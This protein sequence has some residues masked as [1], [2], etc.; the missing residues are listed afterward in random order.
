MRKVVVTLWL[1]WWW[2]GQCF[3]Q[4]PVTTHTHP[5]FHPRTAVS[6]TV[7]NAYGQWRP[8]LNNSPTGKTEPSTNISQPAPGIHENTHHNKEN[9][10]PSVLPGTPS[11]KVHNGLN[12][13][14][15][16]HVIPSAKPPMNTSSDDHDHDASK[17]TSSG[18]DTT[19]GES[20]PRHLPD[21]L[22]SKNETH[23]HIHDHNP[24]HVSGELPVPE[25]STSEQPAPDMNKNTHHS[26]ENTPPTVLPVTQSEKVH[27][28]GLSWNS[29]KHVTPA[30]KPPVKT[31]RNDLANNA[32]TNTSSGNDTSRDDG[33]PKHLPDDP[34]SEHETH[35][36]DHDHNPVY[37]AHDFPVPESSATDNK[38]EGLLFI[39]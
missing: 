26:N 3:C 30:A 29:S 34:H 14:A 7:H 37:V 1:C 18:N 19:R 12:R 24:V 13:N 23:T 35:T 2:V 16:E 22:H 33:G 25:S 17:N 10:T 21:D 27:N 39:T 4:V 28:G 20:G 38:T 8:S 15:S 9:T 11:E 32:S 6:S 31:N 5:G 36:H